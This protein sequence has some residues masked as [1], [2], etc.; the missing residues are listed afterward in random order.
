MRKALLLVVALGLA[1]AIST[2][3][4][5]GHG[6]SGVKSYTGCLV[7]KDGVVIKIKEGVTPASP[8]TGG[9]VEAHLSGGDITKI[10]VE[11]GLTGGGDNGEV[12][13]SLD[14]K[15]SLPQD[16]DDN[17]VAK[18]DDGTGAWVCAADNDTTYSAGTG[19]ALSGT[20]FS[21]ASDYR[22]K[23]TPDCSSGQFAT[24]FDSNGD[25]QCAAPSAPTLQ[26]FQA[27]QT[28]FL[29]GDGVPDD[30]ADRTFVSLAVP[31][32]TYLVTGKGVLHQGDDDTPT[33]STTGGNLGCG[34]GNLP[35]EFTRFYGKDND[36]DE[37]AFALAAIVTTSGEALTL[38]CFADPD[39]DQ[40][41]IRNGTLVAVKVG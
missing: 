27:R 29:S 28:N 35:A 18:W 9:S 39:H 25:I 32:G 5:A 26:T 8:C 13:I 17:E 22:V 34:I 19:L 14:A 21:V 38:R 40:I 41:S 3:A 4:V 30:G 11:G 12:T 36:E 24:G 1:L 6:T 7:P 15:Y 31:A 33:F 2:T 10:S 20:Q 16:C 23:N 37:Y